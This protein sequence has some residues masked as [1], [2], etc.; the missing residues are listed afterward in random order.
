MRSVKLKSTAQIDKHFISQILK[1]R[2]LNVRISKHQDQLN[3]NGEFS[4]SAIAKTLL[5]KESAK[6]H[7]KSQSECDEHL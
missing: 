5:L 7:R 1:R 6:K 3:K 2:N 4:S